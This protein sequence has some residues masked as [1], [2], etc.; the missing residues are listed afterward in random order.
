MTD[1]IVAI[2]NAVKPHLARLEA[3]DIV[4]VAVSGGADS[5]ALAA[6]IL[7][8]ANAYAITPIGSDD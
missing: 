1:A 4:L 8:E 6:A 7:K 5:L 3:G 2:R